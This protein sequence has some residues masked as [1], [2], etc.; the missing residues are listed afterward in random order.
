M[1]GHP[2][3]TFACPRPHL[4]LCSKPPLEVPL[5]AAAQA[6]GPGA[7]QMLTGPGAAVGAVKMLTGPG[8]VEMLTGAGAVEMLTG[9]G[10][11]LAVRLRVATVRRA[12]LPTST[13]RHRLP[14]RAHLWSMTELLPRRRPST[15]EVQAE[16]MEERPLRHLAG[17][18]LLR[19][20]L[21]P[22]RPSPKRRPSDGQRS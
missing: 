14:R 1:A 19:Q 15:L 5:E 3:S 22:P 8:A 20:Q 2:N 16:P 7:V 13:C 6:S 9:P 17:P 11:A 18:S 4:L 12:A 21:R 10:S